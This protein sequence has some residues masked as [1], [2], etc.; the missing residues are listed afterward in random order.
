MNRNFVLLAM[1]FFLWGNITTINSVIILFFSLWFQIS[2]QQAML[3]TVLFYLAPFLSCL[4][5]S[6]LIAHYGYR[7]VLEGSLM[8]SATGCLMLAAAIHEGTFTGALIGVFI[9][10]TGVAAMQVVANPYLALLSPTPRRVSNLSLASAVNSLGTTLAPLCIALL[11]D[12]YPVQPVLRQEPMSALWLVLSILSLAL[13]LGVKTIRLPDVS[14]AV[15]VKDGAFRLW[16][17]P[18]IVSSIIAIFVYV[19]VE[20]ALATSLL[21]Y[22]TLSAGWSA[23]IAVSMI[24]LY[25]GGAL[26]GRLLFG[27]FGRHSHSAVVF[28][29]A[30]LGC[31]L[32]VALAM[33]LNN[34]AGGW[35]LLLA[36][37]GNS[38]MYPIIFAHAIGQQP[39]RANVIAGL[40]VMA[41]IGGAIFPWLQAVMIEALDLRLSFLL[42]LGMYGVLAMWGMYFLRQKAQE[43]VAV[44]L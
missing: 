26:V 35:L 43:S 6:R 13:L 20:V 36:G 41:G 17:N 37:V 30:T 2:W 19:G 18:Q 14:V 11:L 24:T 15:P 34:S 44:S 32:L 28:R 23:D 3:V 8:L 25:W 39:S 5:C 4:P 21:Q 22:L 42:P 16:Q 38:V 33:M 40:M 7:K 10:A 9:A 12:F 29:T 27:L 1:V 31:I